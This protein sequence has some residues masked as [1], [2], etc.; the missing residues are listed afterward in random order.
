MS[1]LV[2]DVINNLQDEVKMIEDQ[3]KERLLKKR[4]QSLINLGLYEKEYSSSDEKTE[5]YPYS[6]L[7]DGKN[8]FYKKKVID[9]NEEDLNK[10]LQ[11]TQQKKELEEVMNHKNKDKNNVASLLLSLGISL[12]FLTFFVGVLSLISGDVAIGFAFI[13]SGLFVGSILYGFSEVI[14][15]LTKIN[16]K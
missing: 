6:E 2:Q 14:K 5:N 11:L 7:K 3:N 1:K 4:N 9:I 13:I 12:Y 16:N 10:I 15:L 8:R